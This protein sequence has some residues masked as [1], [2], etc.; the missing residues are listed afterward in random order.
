MEEGSMTH[1]EMMLEMASHRF[2]ADVTAQRQ[3]REAADLGD[4]K[5]QHNLANAYFLALGGLERD[6]LLAEQWNDKAL[7]NDPDDI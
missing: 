6:V 5:A 2:Q 3:V 7:A 4:A 1:R